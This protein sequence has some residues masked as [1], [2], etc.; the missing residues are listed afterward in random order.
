MPET[1]SR[2]L[3]RILD[4]SAS[5]EDAKAFTSERQHSAQAFNLHVERRDGRHAEGFAWSHYVGYSWTDEG[6]QERLIVLF[7]AR[8]VEIEGH[9]LE[10]LVTEI[11]D[12]Q[13]NSI[14]ELASGQT[15]LLE[16]G[17]PDNQP[18]IANVKLFPDFQEIMREVKGEDDERSHS[19]RHAR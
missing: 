13:L 15:L 5:A 4:K 2:T 8:A 16:Q 10:V 3:Q 1:K 6:Q 12:G 19:K 9:N 11:R 17:N 7:G 14:H 18:I